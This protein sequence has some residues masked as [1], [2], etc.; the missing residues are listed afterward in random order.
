MTSEVIAPKFGRAE[1]GLVETLERNYVMPAVTLKSTPFLRLTLL[2]AIIH[3]PGA[4]P[5]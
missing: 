4:M 5:C 1:G 3:Q 2:A